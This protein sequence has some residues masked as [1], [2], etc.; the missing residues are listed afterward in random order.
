MSTTAPSR[1]VPPPPRPRAGFPRALVV[2]AWLAFAGAIGLGTLVLGPIKGI[3][4]IAGVVLTIIIVQLPIVGLSISLFV[5]TCFQVIGSAHIIGLPLSLSKIFG[6]LTLGGF[7]V[8]FVLQRW[9]AARSAQITGVLPFLGVMLLWT[10]MLDPAGV[11]TEGLVKFLQTLLLFYLIANMAGRSQAWFDI[12][13]WSLLVALATGAFIAILEHF[14]PALQLASDDPRLAQGALG[15]VLDTESV[16]GVVIKR[17]T[18]GMGDSNWFAYAMA[19]GLPLCLA[20]WLRHERLLPRIVLLG[21]AG[22]MAIGLVYSFTRTGFLALAVAILYLVARRTL[23]LL[24]ALAGGLAVFAVALVYVPEGFTDRFFSSRYL[25]E[26]STPIRRD[27]AA[28]AW[29]ITKESP[30]I[31][32]GYGQF[33]NEYVRLLKTDPNL[34]DP[35]VGQWGK[36]IIAEVETGKEDPTNVGAHSLPL[37]LGVE[38][39]AIGVAAYLIWLVS[40]WRDLAFSERHGN[41][42]HRVLAICMK[43]SFIGLMVCAILAH[44]KFLKILWLIAGFAAALAWLVRRS[45]EREAGP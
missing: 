15:A 38:F 36:N 16:T 18:G 28:T 3:G 37:E 4:A 11:A 31:G 14:V 1:E 39:G 42:H 5:N 10:M 7:I 20:L 9:K 44:M 27:L 19:A 12:A 29:A 25:K 45:A 22:L 6:A 40:F 13:L 21:I 35:R 43:A 33:G 23:P 30:L 26:G 32:H 34:V 17:V 8:Q 41:A 24:P 2:L